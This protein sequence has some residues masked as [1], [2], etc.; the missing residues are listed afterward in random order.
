[1]AHLK[2]LLDESNNKINLNYINT[3]TVKMSEASG[4]KMSHTSKK[5]PKLKE[6]ILIYSKSKNYKFNELTTEKDFYVSNY[7]QYYG[8]NCRKL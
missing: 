5:L 3:V 8:N 4:V 1:M 2:V 6:Y 7:L